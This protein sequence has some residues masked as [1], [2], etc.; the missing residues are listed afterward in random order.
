[1]GE[2]EPLPDSEWLTQG[3]GLYDAVRYGVT[4]PYV[5][6]DRVSLLGSPAVARQLAKHCSA[7]TTV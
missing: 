4:L 1:M 7:I 6:T 2:S 5:D 3:R